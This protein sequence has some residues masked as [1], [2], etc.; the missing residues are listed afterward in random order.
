MPLPRL[1]SVVVF[2]NG[3]KLTEIIEITNNFHSTSRLFLEVYI[4]TILFSF[5][6][7]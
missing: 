1:G 5:A 6:V 4:H 7:V 3:S 2:N